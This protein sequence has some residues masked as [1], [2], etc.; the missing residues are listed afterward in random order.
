MWD[1]EDNTQTTYKFDSVGGRMDHV[2]VPF[3]LDTFIFGLGSRNGNCLSDIYFFSWR[4]KQY[5][6]A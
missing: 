6:R 1:V 4:D 2:L 3:D 5:E